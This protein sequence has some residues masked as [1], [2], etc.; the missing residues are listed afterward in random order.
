MTIYVT[1]GVCDRVQTQNQNGIVRFT[2]PPL[3]Q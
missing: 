3:T 2:S 1:P